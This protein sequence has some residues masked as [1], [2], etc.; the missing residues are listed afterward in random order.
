MNKYKVEF[1]HI[2]TYIIDVE[3]NTEEEATNIAIQK[4]EQ[5]FNNG[6][7]HYHE[8]GDPATNISNIYDVT[9]TDDPFNP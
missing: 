6:T 9:N 4:L 7:Y 5:A 1:Q 8:I 3:A 2:E